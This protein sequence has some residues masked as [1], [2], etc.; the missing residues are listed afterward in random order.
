MFRCEATTATGERLTLYGHCQTPQAA[1]RMVL[2]DWRRTGVDV[3][4]VAI[5]RG[6]LATGKPVL[7]WKESS[8]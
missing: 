4:A 7:T 6:K 1:L 8:Q 2:E 3:R 5:W